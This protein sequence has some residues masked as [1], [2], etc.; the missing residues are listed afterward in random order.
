MKSLVL[1]GLAGTL[2][3]CPKL[4][5]RRFARFFNMIFRRERA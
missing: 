2:T 1:L 3:A 5:R 4:R